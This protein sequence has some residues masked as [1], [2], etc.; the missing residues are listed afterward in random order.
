MM[1]LF[2]IVSIALVA[3][4]CANATRMCGSENVTGSR[5]LPHPPDNAANLLHL[6]RAEQTQFP[7]G[8]NKHHY[9]FERPDGTFLLCRQN[10]DWQ[11]TT[12]EQ[13]VFAFVL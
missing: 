8:G 5:Q 6:V 9:W 7:Y 13:F 11:W 1:K 2:L 12:P 10:P 3:S 4:G